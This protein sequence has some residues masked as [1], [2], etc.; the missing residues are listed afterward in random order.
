MVIEDLKVLVNVH[1]VFQKDLKFLDRHL[2]N[3][4]ALFGILGN[5]RVGWEEDADIVRCFA[6]VVGAAVSRPHVF[7][8][9]QAV[10]VVPTDHAASG[11]HSS[12]DEG[13]AAAGVIEADSD[14][15]LILTPRPDVELLYLWDHIG[16]GVCGG[17]V[18][19]GGLVLVWVQLTSLIQDHIRV[20][21][22]DCLAVLKL[23][24]QVA[25]GEGQHVSI[26]I[27]FSQLGRHTRAQELLPC[28]L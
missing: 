19:W 5:G 2:L 22:Q 21:I 26:S 3:A 20:V 13:L 28:P 11:G 4:V 18:F 14:P 23:H 10:L 1:S 25:S 27:C 8:D 7:R 15:L 17:A 9:G 24:V 12:D 16:Q 6:V